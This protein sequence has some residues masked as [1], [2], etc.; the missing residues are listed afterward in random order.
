MVEFPHISSFVNV[1]FLLLSDKQSVAE[2]STGNW[3]FR[4][5]QDNLYWS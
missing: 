4:T 5:Q 3:G 1:H 2:T